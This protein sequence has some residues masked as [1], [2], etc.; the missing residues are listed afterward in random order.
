MIESKTENILLTLFVVLT[1][2]LGYYTLNKTS[3]QPKKDLLFMSTDLNTCIETSGGPCC[4]EYA[5]LMNEAKR[6]GI[7]INSITSCN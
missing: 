5:D 4:K 7:E 1:F 6:V 3:A 2:A